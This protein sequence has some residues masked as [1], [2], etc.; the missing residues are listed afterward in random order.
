MNLYL[1]LKKYCIPKCWNRNV[2]DDSGFI[3]PKLKRAPKYW[4][5]FDKRIIVTHY[6]KNALFTI[7][8]VSLFIGIFQC[9]T[10]PAYYNDSPSL[11][12]IV[13]WILYGFFVYLILRIITTDPG[14][15]PKDKFSDSL[16]RIVTEDSLL[17]SIA[18]YNKNSQ[19]YCS[20]CHH[21]MP[22]KTI[23]CKRCNCCVVELDHHCKILGVCI[24]RRNYYLFVMMLFVLAI[25]NF[26]SMF[27]SGSFILKEFNMSERSEW[28]NI[29]T[30]KYPFSMALILTNMLAFLPILYMNILHCQLISYEMGTY[31]YFIYSLEPSSETRLKKWTFVRMLRNYVKLFKRPTPPS[32]LRIGYIS[33]DKLSSIIKN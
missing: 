15:I 16:R 25:L 1:K 5:L 24:G 3:I 21:N 28:I 14:I 27:I 9:E 17:M 32:L 18:T 10:L 22:Q 29:I 8:V 11:L 33:D 30:I 31:N 2:D 6:Y 20:V 23:H 7:F 26:I 4:V 13:M 19:N 12:K